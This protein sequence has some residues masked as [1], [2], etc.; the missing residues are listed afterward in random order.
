MTILCFWIFIHIHVEKNDKLMSILYALVIS[1]VVIAFKSKSLIIFY[2]CYEFRVV[3]TMLIV[4]LYGYQPEK[5]R[6]AF[7]LL[8]YTVVRR[9]PLFYFL[10][11]GNLDCMR[12]ILTFWVTLGF[13]VKTPLYLFHTWLPKAHVEA[14]VGGSIILAG[15]L[16]KLG[17]YGLFIFL[18]HI[19][20]NGILSYYLRISLI[21][22]IVGSLICIRQGDM[23][24]FIAY[25]SV[26]HIG[27]VTLGLIRGTETGYCCALIIVFR[28]GFVSPFL[29]AFRFWLYQSSHSRLL[30]NNKSSITFILLITIN[31]GVPPRLGLWSEVFMLKGVLNISISLFPIL[32]LILLLRVIYNLLLYILTIPNKILKTKYNYYSVGQVTFLCYGSLFCLD[33]FHIYSHSTFYFPHQY[34]LIYKKSQITSTKCQYQALASKP[35]WWR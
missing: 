8:L 22:S 12:G 7:S 30:V 5:L 2:I 21:G 25:S 9:L 35:K 14:P 1:R 3:P 6:A 20:I 11:I 26:V 4:F 31:I 10:L 13:I 16:L 23:K 17:S 19:K 15:L 18:P 27:I 28:H 34:I 29:F 32:I 33:L 24:M